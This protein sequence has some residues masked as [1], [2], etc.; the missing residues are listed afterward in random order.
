MDSSYQTPAQVL[1]GSK[2][3]PKKKKIIKKKAPAAAPKKKIIKKK[4]PDAAP[5]KKVK[6]IIR[7]KAPANVANKDMKCFMRTARNG[8][9]YRAC[10]VPEGNKQPKRQVRAN[11]RP[12]AERVKPYIT[13]YAGTSQ[14]E[15]NKASRAA[16]KASK[17]APAPA[18]KKKI[19]IKKKP[20]E[21]AAPKKIKIIKKKER[22]AAQKA[23]DKKLGEMAKKKKII[24]K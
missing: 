4:A 13:A 6:L 15:R 10:A 18:K 7:K 23:N 16:N 11:P 9:T 12:A 14:A 8:A 17:V 1:A 24:K 5:K 22:S 20:K 2:T 3:A 19:I 21:D